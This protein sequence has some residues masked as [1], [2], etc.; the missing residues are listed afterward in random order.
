MNQISKS[1]A[2]GLIE[3]GNLPQMNSSTFVNNMVPQ[4]NG[5]VERMN[6]TVQQM[7]RAMLDESR[8]LATFWGEA[9][10]STVTILNKTNVQVNN[11]QT[12]H[13]LW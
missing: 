3:E 12:P 1:N 7:A 10:F 2:S 8:T 4:Q 11:T 9:A 13:E 6:R 5:V